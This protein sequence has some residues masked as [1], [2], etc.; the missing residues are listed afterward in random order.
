MRGLVPSYALGLI[1]NTVYVSSNE[2]NLTGNLT[3]NTTT[4]VNT[5]SELNVVKFA[6]AEVIAGQDEPVVFTISVTNSGPSDALNV[7]V[8][9]VLDSRLTNQEYSLINV[10]WFVW[11]SPFEYVFSRVN[12]TQTVYFYLRGLVPSNATGLINNTV[13]VSSN[14]TNLTG[15]L[16]DNTT[17]VIDTLA[18][19][20]ITKTSQTEGSDVNHIVPG[21][22]INYTIVVTNEGP[23]DALNVTF[24]D[25]YTPDLLENTYYSHIK[26]NS[27]DS[28]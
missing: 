8:S 13:Y 12:A 6:P 2:T 28:L 4:V 25:Y 19:L 22:S 11:S 1:N 15:N 27:L 21:Y 17:T 5:S 24:D 23:S 14:T 18:I 20:N 7:K 10:D 3:D 16:T 26:W 9:D